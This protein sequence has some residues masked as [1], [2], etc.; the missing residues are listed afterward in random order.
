MKFYLL[1]LWKASFQI[2]INQPKDFDN[3]V[4]LSFGKS[5]SISFSEGHNVVNGDE[6]EHVEV[7]FCMLFFGNLTPFK[8]ENRSKLR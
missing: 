6:F 4:S 3:N 5:C 1:I 8:T 7:Y 2:L